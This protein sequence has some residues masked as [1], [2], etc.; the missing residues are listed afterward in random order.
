LIIAATTV[1]SGYGW[2]TSLVILMLGLAKVFESISDV[3]F[4]LL[5]QHEPMDRI[6]KSMMVKGPLSLVAL[7]GAIALTGN[8]VWGAVAL[9][10]A[11]ALWLVVYDIPNGAALLHA[12]EAMRPLWDGRR[13]AR[14]ARRAPPLGL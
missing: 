10:T 1:V 7:T 3:F 2:Q 8:I 11:W 14:P 9:A 4:G 6:A 12:A 13:L 5:Q